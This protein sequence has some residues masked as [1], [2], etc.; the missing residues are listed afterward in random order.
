MWRCT[1]EAEFSGTSVGPVFFARG[2]MANQMRF[3]S[4][5]AQEVVVR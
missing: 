1:F 2:G 3:F 4:R 5:E